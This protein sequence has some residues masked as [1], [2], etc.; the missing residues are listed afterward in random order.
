MTLDAVDPVTW[1]WY[2]HGFCRSHVASV[3]SASNYREGEVKRELRVHNYIH[4]HILPYT[5]VVHV[6]MYSVHAHE[7]N[8]PRELD[9]LYPRASA[10]MSMNIHVHMWPSSFP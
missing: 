1:T 7:S 2:I 5:S 9:A 3:Y 10:V 6:Y 4:V 8:C